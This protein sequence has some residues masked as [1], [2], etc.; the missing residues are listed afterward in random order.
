MDVLTD[1][2]AMRDRM[3]Q[4][5]DAVTLVVVLSPHQ[6]SFASPVLERL[7]ATRRQKHLRVWI[8]FQKEKEG[9]GLDQALRVFMPKDPRLIAVWDEKGEIPTTLFGGDGT[10]VGIY[11]PRSVWGD[12]PPVPLFRANALDEEQVGLELDQALSPGKSAQR[13]F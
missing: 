13:A 1:V 11:G 3:N 4:N 12:T 6:A 7:L 9:D 2:G 8:L 5:Q 10:R